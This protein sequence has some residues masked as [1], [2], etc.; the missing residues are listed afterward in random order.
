MEAAQ[1]TTEHGTWCNTCGNVAD[2]DTTFS[3]YGCSHPQCNHSNNEDD[4]NE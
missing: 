1:F 2:E 3:H 4:D